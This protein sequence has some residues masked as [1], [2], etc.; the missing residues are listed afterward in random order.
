MM[1][2]EPARHF[3]PDEGDEPAPHP[4]VPELGPEMPEADVLEQWQS[5]DPADIGDGPE[6]IPPDA[7]EADALDQ[8][9]VVPFDDE[10]F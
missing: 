5:T 2:D 8:T 9:R 6:T 7:S 10:P 4:A 3:E 1:R